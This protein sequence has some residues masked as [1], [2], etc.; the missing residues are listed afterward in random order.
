MSRRRWRRAPEARSSRCMPLGVGDFGD[1]KGSGSGS[2]IRGS[3]QQRGDG[4]EAT[5]IET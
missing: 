4:R 2:G 1:V 5:R 3:G